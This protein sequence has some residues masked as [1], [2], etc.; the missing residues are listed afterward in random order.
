[1]RKLYI[2][3]L[4][5]VALLVIGIAIADE[6]KFSTYYP[7]PAGKYREFST[8][9]KTCLATDEFNIETDA[10]VGIG[11]TN[12]QRTLHIDG[13]YGMRLEPSTLLPVPAATGDIVIHSDQGKNILKYYDGEDWQA[14]GGGGGGIKSIQR[15]TKQFPVSGG[16]GTYGD[17]Q[18]L[19]ITDINLTTLTPAITIENL[20]KTELKI[21]LTS[22]MAIPDFSAIL[23][24]ATNL[25]IYVGYVS[26][27]AFICQA[28][29][30]IT[31][32][33]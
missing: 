13:T 20:A 8:T 14:L 10:M 21:Q 24:S 2:V 32:Y 26:A 3:G 11:T 16:T 28:T 30:E 5:A 12:P 25:R 27:T 22:D 29:F 9:G 15:G 1:M 17:V 19:H 6:I 33:E 4:I 7:A 18:N 23:T 31:E